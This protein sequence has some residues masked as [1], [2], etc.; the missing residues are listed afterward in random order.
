MPSARQRPSSPTAR[1]SNSTLTASPMGSRIELPA[2]GGTLDVTWQVASVTMPMSRVELI[3][4]GEIRQSQAVAPDD[5]QRV[6]VDQGG[7]ELLDGACW[8]AGIIRTSPRS[9]PPIPPRS[10]CR[11]PGRRCLAAADAV[12][13]LEQIEGALAYLDTVGTRAEDRRLQTHA[14]GARIGPPPPAQPHAPGRPFPRA[15]PGQRSPGAPL[16]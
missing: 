9:S 8:C 5:S 11:W 6:L 10:W 12:T 3:V 4:N 14:P 1:C 7:S 2:S 13:I 15:Y 16:R